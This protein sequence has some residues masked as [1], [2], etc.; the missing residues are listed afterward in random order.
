MPI[1]FLQ[2]GGTLKGRTLNVSFMFMAI[3]DLEGGE[4]RE[5]ERGWEYVCVCV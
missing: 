1:D 4:E 2:T 3:R 5:R